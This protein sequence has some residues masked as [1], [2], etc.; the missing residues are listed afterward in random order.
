M[1]FY[2]HKHYSNPWK[3]GVDRGLKK[4]GGNGEGKSDYVRTINKVVQGCQDNL[5]KGL[6]LIN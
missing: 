6:Q 4:G 1:Q 2:F 5:H 3:M